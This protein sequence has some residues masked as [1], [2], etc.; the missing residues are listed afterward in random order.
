MLKLLER[1]SQRLVVRDAETKEVLSA[2]ILPRDA[3]RKTW[4][5]FLKRLTN[6]G[7][8][9]FVVLHNIATGIPQEV[10][11]TDGRVA[12]K[13]PSFEVRRQAALDLLEFMHG[14]AVA[15]TEVVKAEEQTQELAQIEAMSVDELKA[16]AAPFL[17]RGDDRT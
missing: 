5:S 4:R 2:V 7:E 13:L 16:I 1:Q 11:L 12:L 3:A 6:N 9:L 10:T 8:D 14:K 15:Q 17:E